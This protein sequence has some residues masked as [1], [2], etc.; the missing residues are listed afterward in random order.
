MTFA[1]IKN[2]TFRVYMSLIQLTMLV[3]R[4][5]IES[6]G[7]IKSALVWMSC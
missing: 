1:G 7:G 6:A 4:P 2:L 3:Q 5:Q